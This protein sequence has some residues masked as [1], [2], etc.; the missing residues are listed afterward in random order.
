[1]DRIVLLVYCS[2]SVL[3]CNR[4]VLY[5]ADE[6]LGWKCINHFILFYFACMLHFIYYK[7]KSHKKSYFVISFKIILRVI[8][9]VLLIMLLQKIFD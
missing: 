8:H 5:Y 9:L 4:V 1:M 2:I 7:K 6:N 3:C